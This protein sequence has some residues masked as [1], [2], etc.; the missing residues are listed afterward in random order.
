MHLKNDQSFLYRYINTVVLHTLRNGLLAVTAADSNA[1]ND[2]SLFSLVTQAASLV[3]T[4]WTGG[5]MN[6]VQLTILPATNANVSWRI[7]VQCSFDNAPNA[8]EKSENIRLFLFVELADVL[9]G[10]HLAAPG[11]SIIVCQLRS[12]FQQAY[13]VPCLGVEDVEP[14]NMGDLGG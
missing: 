13:Y 5:S 6:N 9:V 11:L 3:R 7:Q 1:I 10:T 2:I 8:E 14:D 4:R 12:F